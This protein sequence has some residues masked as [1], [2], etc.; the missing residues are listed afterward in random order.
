MLKKLNEV[1]SS[2]DIAYIVND[3]F[4]Q[5]EDMLFDQGRL[6]YEA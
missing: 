5:V 2:A 4:M 6:Q 3:V 1:F